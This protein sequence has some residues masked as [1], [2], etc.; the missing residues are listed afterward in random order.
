MDFETLKTKLTAAGDW[1]AAWVRLM[2]AALV[3]SYIAVMAGFGTLACFSPAP[4]LTAK[5]PV[6]YLTDGDLGDTR[7]ATLALALGQ[8]QSAAAFNDRLDKLEA[9]QH[10]AP[11]GQSVT[12][13]ST[14]KSRR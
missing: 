1:L 10:E 5:A 4:A 13:G 12:T 6:A 11:K 3:V 9:W 2:P 7:N 14:S 8:R